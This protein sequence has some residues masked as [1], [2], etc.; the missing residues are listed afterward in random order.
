[1]L[2]KELA[3]EI[4]QRT[5]GIIDCNVNI[6]DREGRIIGSGEPKR[7]N[8][9]HEGA[10]KVIRKQTAIEFSRKEIDELD[11]T[12]PGINLPIRFQG[13]I[14]GVIG[15]T[16]EP[17]EIRG[18]AQLVQ[19][20]AELTLEHA[21]L[22]QEIQSDKSVKESTLSH[23]LL[24]TET[25]DTFVEER[26]RSLG[27]NIH[28]YGTVFLFS[29]PSRQSRTF[30]NWLEQRI[31]EE[32]DEF[33]PLY[34]SELIFLRKGS[35]KAADSA[36]KEINHWLSSS[37]FQGVTASC[38]PA[39]YGYKGWRHS[40]EV[41]RLLN[42]T[43]A[44]LKKWSTVWTMES[45]HTEAMCYGFYQNFPKESFPLIQNYQKVLLN[46][47]GDELHKTLFAFIEEN[48]EM[49]KTAERLYI[50][51]NTLAYRLEKIQNITGKNPKLINDLFELKVSLLFALI[52]ENSVS[53]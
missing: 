35:T 12:L 10:Q 22:A 6:M 37:S 49:M 31:A 45:L 16:G 51:R 9:V 27:I 3:S 20:G 11:G 42:N 17:E 34:T 30:K 50:H 44:A 48:G 36:R 8:Q 39:E 23:L 38:G 29:L 26:A 24:G 19:M 43:A 7:L 32:G 18:F 53:Q 25:D 52:D 13:T 2:N 47:N 40:F 46:E 21:A 1:M 33:I 14:V 41:A 28:A 5:M 4:V 15:L